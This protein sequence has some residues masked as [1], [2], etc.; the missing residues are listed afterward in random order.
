MGSNLVGL[1]GRLVSSERDRRLDSDVGE[2]EELKGRKDCKTQRQ[3]RV[4]YSSS[5][6]SAL[7]SKTG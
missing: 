1:G 6:I 5:S 4:D 7:A 3:I 2:V